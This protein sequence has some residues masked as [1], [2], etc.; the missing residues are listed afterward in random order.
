MGA[1]ITLILLVLVCHSPPTW[2]SETQTPL[3]VPSPDDT[4]VAYMTRDDHGNCFMRV[5]AKAELAK[6]SRVAVS[7]SVSALEWSP[8]GDKFAFEAVAADGFTQ[9][10]FLYDLRSN[11]IQDLIPSSSPFFVLHHGTVISEWLDDNKLAFEQQCGT[12][13]VSLSMIDLKDQSRWYFCSGNDE[14]H[15]SPDKQLAVVTVDAPYRQGGLHLLRVQDARPL[16]GHPESWPGPD[17][18][19]T[20]EGCLYRQPGN[21]P[22]GEYLTFK[23]WSPD[24]KSFLYVGRDCTHGLPGASTPPIVYKYNVETFEIEKV[25]EKKG[26]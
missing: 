16:V 19:P 14:F 7:C 6:P 13:C 15:W 18:C 5:A 23:S 9:T 4:H 8:R 22:T 3:R 24:S 2:A 25:S 1:A 17:C 21:M 20:L 10:I 11:R 26:N 12:D